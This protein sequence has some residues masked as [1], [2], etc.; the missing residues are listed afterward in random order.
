[1]VSQLTLA[2]PPSPSRH[3]QGERDPLPPRAE[4]RSQ[5]LV[6][7]DLRRQ[8][9]VRLVLPRHADVQHAAERRR[10]G[11]LGFNL[12]SATHSGQLNLH[13]DAPPAVPVPIVGDVHPRVPFDR[14]RRSR[15][16]RVHERFRSVVE[17]GHAH[18]RREVL[19][20]GAVVFGD[21][22][23]AR[24][25]RARRPGAAGK[26]PSSIPRLF[27]LVGVEVRR[28]GAE[29]PSREVRRPGPRRSRPAVVLVLALFGLVVRVPR[30]RVAREPPA[31]AAVRERP[32]P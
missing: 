30:G 20:G 29:A 16:A 32:S 17:A 9:N 13:H 27:L 11:E 6:P 15:G 22:A 4:A 7:V 23:A 1:M 19:R 25:L 26:H 8:P 28:P 2:T 24:P 14:S 12:P 5:R 31:A 21:A 10:V 18:A 3:R